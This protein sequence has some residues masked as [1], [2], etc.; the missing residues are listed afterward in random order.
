M[1][2]RKLKSQLFIRIHQHINELISNTWEIPCLESLKWPSPH[3]MQNEHRSSAETNTPLFACGRHIPDLKCRNESGPE[4]F[5]S[6]LAAVSAHL[7][8]YKWVFFLRFLSYFLKEKRN[9]GRRKILLL[10][11][12]RTLIPA[13]SIYYRQINP[14]NRHWHDLL[15][16]LKPSRGAQH[17]LVAACVSAICCLSGDLTLLAAMSLLIC[18]F[19]FGW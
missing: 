5:P 10:F 9:Y 15:G 11:Q 13:F 7:S 12:L 17:P 18:S 8:T 2:S 4:S 3:K 19:L 16:R 6:P 1:R 14:P